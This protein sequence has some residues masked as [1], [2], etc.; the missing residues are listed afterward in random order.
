MP[1]LSP[2]P[3]QQIQFEQSFCGA[4]L[5]GVLCVSAL[6]EN[7]FLVGHRCELREDDPLFVVDLVFYMD[8]PVWLMIDSQQRWFSFIFDDAN[9]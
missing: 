7:I 9:C 4:F 3:P 6:H 5:S 8:L 2:S 1:S